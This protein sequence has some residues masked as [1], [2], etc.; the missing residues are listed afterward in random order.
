MYWKNYSELINAEYIERKYWHSSKVVYNYKGF[1]IIFDHYVIYSNAGYGSFGST[2]TRIYCQFESKRA[3]N[4]L[5][6]KVTLYS[7]IISC[8]RRNRLKIGHKE[9]DSKYNM[10]LSGGI[11]HTFLSKPIISKIINYNIIDLY[12]HNKNAIWG[13]SLDKNNYE[14]ATYINDYKVKTHVLT[15]FKSLFEEIIDNLISNHHISSPC[16]NPK[17]LEP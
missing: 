4:L 8:F 3:I 1:K 10:F 6:E 11:S 9:F 5:I 17:A 16:I 2:V 12:I 13:E 14:L 7:K 15:N